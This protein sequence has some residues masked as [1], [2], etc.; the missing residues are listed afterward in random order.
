MAEV[1]Q[2]NTTLP[3]AFARRHVGY[4]KDEV[5]PLTHNTV[6]DDEKRNGRREG[7]QGDG[8]GTQA[9]AY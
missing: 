7:R 8:H 3:A 4:E 1:R 2:S 6:T 5:A 9:R